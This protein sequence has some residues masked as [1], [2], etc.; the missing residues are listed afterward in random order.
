KA[1]AG[2]GLSTTTVCQAS[3]SVIPRLKDGG[4]R[5]S[6]ES[7]GRAVLSGG[8][9]QEQAKTHLVEGAFGS[10]L[11]V[12]ELAVPR[13]CKP[14]AVHASAHMLSFTEPNPRVKY[15]IEGSTDGGKSWTPVVKDWQI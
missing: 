2:S 8:A 10:P 4:T 1:L 13:D 9:T 14:L 12:L 5:V 3:V 7:S 15:Q 6:F 11:A